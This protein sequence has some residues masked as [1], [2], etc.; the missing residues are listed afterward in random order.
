MSMA[1]EY[2][3]EA[4]IIVCGTCA[5]FLFLPQPVEIHGPLWVMYRKTCSTSI[6]SE[7]NFVFSY[8]SDFKHTL[9]P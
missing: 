8:Q 5:M 4:L 3:I 2:L 1:Q 7:L 6:C 9:M